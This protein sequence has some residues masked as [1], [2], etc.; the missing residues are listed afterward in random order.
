VQFETDVVQQFFE[1]LVISEHPF[2]GVLYEHVEILL[3][4]LRIALVY[5]S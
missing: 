4:D 1:D 3:E 5:Q 2:Y